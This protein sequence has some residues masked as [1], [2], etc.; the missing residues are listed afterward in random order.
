MLAPSADH[1][2]RTAGAPQFWR[3]NPAAAAALVVAIAGAL[4]IAGAW[5]FELV[6]KLNPCPMCLEQRWPYYIGIPLALIVAL[7]AGRRAPR[8][9]VAGGLLALAGLML[10]GV[11][12]GVFHAGVEWKW[13]LGP[14]ECSGAGSFGGPGSLLDR[15]KTINITRCDEAA[16]RLLGISLAGYNALISAALA[17]IALLG[18]RA[19]AKSA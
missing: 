13:W 4:T 17:A 16:W 2:P 7:A 19:A 3:A 12:M 15:L 10:W 6:I 18:A 14:Q 8:M 9:L 1:A 11:Y 5:F